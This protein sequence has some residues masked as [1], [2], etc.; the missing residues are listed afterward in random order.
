MCTAAQVSRLEV[1]V[2]EPSGAGYNRL[3][4]WVSS[5]V[6]HPVL[7]EARGRLAIEGGSFLGGKADHFGSAIQQRGDLLG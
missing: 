3:R 5:P 7:G 1:L 6:E 4:S 2:G